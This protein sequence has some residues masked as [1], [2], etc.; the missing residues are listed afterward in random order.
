[1]KITDGF[2]VCAVTS[3]DGQLG[4]ICVHA[5]RQDAVDWLAAFWDDPENPGTLH[6]RYQHALYRIAEYQGGAPTGS[7][8]WVDS[9][10]NT[11]SM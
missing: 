11:I 6:P 10:G 3:A 8:W 9:D 2:V 7:E 4:P 1:M 5:T